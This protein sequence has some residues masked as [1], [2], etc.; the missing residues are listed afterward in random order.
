MPNAAI[1][2]DRLQSLQVALEFAPQ[3]AFDFD[4]VV[5]NRVDDVVQL[6]RF[7]TFRAQ[8]GIDICLLQNPLRCGRPDPVNVRERGFD[9]FVCWNFN[10]E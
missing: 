9:A 10:S 3:I 8:I 6:L 2:I 1:T 4:L 7:Q 5:R